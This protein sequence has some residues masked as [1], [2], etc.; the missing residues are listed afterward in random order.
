MP[1]LEADVHVVDDDASVRIAL[2]KLLTVVGFRAHVYESVEEFLRARQADAPS[3]LV[4]DVRLPGM[5][6]LDFQDELSRRGT[7]IPVIFITAQGDSPMTRRAMKAG[8]VDFLTKPFRKKELLAAIEQAL[9][10]DRARRKERELLAGLE[11]RLATLT[12]REREV[13]ELVVTGRLNKE[14]GEALTLS[15]ATVKIHRRR[16]MAKMQADSLAELVLMSEKLKRR[17]TT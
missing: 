7:P 4:L 9:D 1:N 14:I 12:P 17:T 5:S 2:K 11:S 3:C 16:V 13:F 8:A 15:E 6:G 10:R